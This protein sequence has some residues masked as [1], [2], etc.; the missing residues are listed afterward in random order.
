MG[1]L[2]MAAAIVAFAERDRLTTAMPLP[3]YAT[4][5]SILLVSAATS[6]I[7]LLPAC[8]FL[9]CLSIWYTMRSAPA[10]LAGRI[11]FAFISPWLIF[12]CPIVLWTWVQSGSP[13][14]PVLAGLFGPSI[15]SQTFIAEAFRK[16]LQAN[17]PSVGITI[18]N[19][20][21]LV[22]LGV[23]G[24]VCGTNLALTMRVSLALLF[25]LQCSLI[26]LLLP[27][28]PRF[29]GG[30]PYGM[31][32]IFA[33]R[34]S[35]ELQT[36]LASRRPAIIAST[37]FLLPWL[38]V[39]LYY[40]K[41]FLRVSLGLE[42]HSF[43]QRYVAFYDDYVRLDKLLPKNTILL[44]EDRRISSVYAPRPIFF[45]PQDVPAGKRVVLLSSRRQRTGRS[46]RGYQVGKVIYSNPQAVVA[47]YRTPG[48][49][50][51]TGFI[52]VIELTPAIISI[53]DCGDSSSC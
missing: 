44:S 51:L 2:A 34:A 18:L 30:I 33:S 16:T 29:L 23:I 19:Y 37:V 12:Y 5:V 15:Y 10:S 24:S 45:D 47:T 8:V 50:P 40:T 14:G 13:F 39:Q 53:D 49:A 26:Y 52:Q 31:L 4:M 17:A 32:I 3:S 41:Q 6:K 36:L 46:I 43:Y 21:P 27:H 38:L 48:R 7:S 1:D 25:G 28:D 22:W 35:P 11:A 9:F 42:K 20:S